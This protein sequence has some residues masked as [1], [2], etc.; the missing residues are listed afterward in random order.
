ML[1]IIRQGVKGW[2]GWSIIGLICLTFALF[3]LNSYF[4]GPVDPIVANINGEEIKQSEFR[5]AY[6]QYR[7]RIRNMM[8]ENYSPE[9]V[10]G[11][12]AKENVL[13]GLIDE[14]VLF[15][16]GA[17]L[18]QYISDADLSEIVKNTPVFQKDGVFDRQTYIAILSR[19]GMTTDIY[20]ARLR[21][22][23]L[24]KEFMGNA[25]QTMFVTDSQI[26]AQLRLQNQTREVAYGVISVED[27]LPTVTIDEAEIQAYYDSNLENYQSPERLTVDYIDVSVD[28]LSKE[29][30]IV[31]EDLL[32]FYE[33]RR[34][35]FVDPEQRSASHI[36]LEVNGENDTAILAKLTDIQ[37]RLAQ[38]ED[39]SALA[40]EL[41]EDIGSAKK[42]GGLG[43]FPRGVMGDSFDTA[44]FELAAVGDVSDI[45]EGEGGYH[46]IKLTGIREPTEKGFDTVRTEVEAL[47][48]TQQAETKFYD[49][50]EQLAELSYENPE[51]LEITAEELGLEIQ[52]TE[53]FTRGGGT[54]IAADKKVIAAA[55]SDDVLAND[56]NSEVI[57]LSKDRS[58]V[59]HLNT[60]TA[61]S[62][63]PLAA[64]S[65][66]IKTRL[67][68][69]KAREQAMT[70]GEEKL[71]KLRAGELAETL[72]VDDGAWQE[73]AAYTR[74]DAGLNPQIRQQVFAMPRPVAAQT[75]YKGFSVQN[76]NYI[77]A[78]LYNVVDA[79]VIE[80]DAAIREQVLTQLKQSM[81]SSETQA[82]IAS[83]KDAAE[84]EVFTKH[85]E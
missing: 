74:T 65:E 51:N 47:Y 71:A 36:L 15:Q 9:M 84:I 38:G 44:V 30:E 50:V 2:V 26:D 85:L 62:Q 57:E 54:G 28:T 21:T 32:A 40:T 60:H 8:G 45:V 24:S 77:V 43:Y 17:N 37:A 63:L 35:Q 66:I 7:N 52:T 1:E 23:L 27:Y 73:K 6:D 81:G 12:A 10:E 29:V 25:Q 33:E 48:R 4:N 49:L 68:A 64:V 82:L 83:L 31:E 53:A 46:L 59:L 76:G 67:S 69:E 58:V 13:S 41:S 14:K 22:D 3:G 42:A 20:E 56:L 5:R 39:F 72:F 34:A 11:M 18:G 80:V 78:A 79:E 19:N 75:L 55:F 70:V 16:A 61:A